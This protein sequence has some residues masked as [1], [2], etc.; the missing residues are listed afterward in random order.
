[1]YFKMNMYLDKIEIWLALNK[2]LLNMDKTIFIA[3][4]NYCDSIPRNIDI[5]INGKSIKRVGM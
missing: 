4:G 3:F 2:L 5:Q 1:M